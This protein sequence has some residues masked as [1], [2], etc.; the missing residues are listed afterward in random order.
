MAMDE[1]SNRAGRYVRQ[2]AGYRAFLPAPPPV[3]GHKPR[4]RQV[5]PNR[6]QAVGF[7]AGVGRIREAV[8]RVLGAQ[9]RDHGADDLSG[10]WLAICAA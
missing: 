4:R 5:S 6:Q 8:R 10:L 1:R 7:S 3:S 2:P 9:Y